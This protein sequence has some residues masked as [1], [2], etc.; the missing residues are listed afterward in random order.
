M[1]EKEEPQEECLYCH[2]L[3]YVDRV[4]PKCAQARF[5]EAKQAALPPVFILKLDP[6]FMLVH[7]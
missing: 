3:A 2:N 7:P 4:C 5:E 1:A 6:D